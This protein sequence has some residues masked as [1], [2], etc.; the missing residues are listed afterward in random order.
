MEL[1]GK[2]M[3]QI[4]AILGLST[5]AMKEW[6]MSQSI[7]AQCLLL[8]NCTSEKFAKKLIGRK[9]VEDAFNRIDSLTKDE[10]IMAVAKRLEVSFAIDGSIE[11]RKK[12]AENAN[13]RLP[14]MDENSVAING[15]T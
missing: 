5:K 12:L 4:L 10:A 14:A 1:L 9:D 6:R 15:G 2:I 11:G 7:H 13:I 8:I 3:A